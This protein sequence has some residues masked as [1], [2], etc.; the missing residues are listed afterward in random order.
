MVLNSPKL[1]LSTTW[2]VDIV[3]SQFIKW[4]DNANLTDKQ[5]TQKLLL[6]LLLLGGQR[7]DTIYSFSVSNMLVTDISIAFAP[8]NV[9]KHSRK[10]SKLGNFCYKNYPQ[11]PSLCVVTCCVKYLQRRSKRIDKSEDRLFITYGK[12]YKSA[13]IDTLRR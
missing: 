13:S 11:E 6:L 12:P 4:G 2:D 10:G 5:I 1:K 7:M 9:L 8:S 3:F